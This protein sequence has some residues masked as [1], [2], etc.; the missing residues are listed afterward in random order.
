M[1]NEMKIEGIVET[2]LPLETFDSGFTKRV[3]VINTGGDY[4]QTVPVE[5]VKDK[6]EVLTGLTKG[7]AVTAHINI[8]GNEYNG[9]YYCN[10][11]GWKLDK[12]EAWK[13][14]EEPQAKA[15]PT[16]GNADDGEIP[17]SPHHEGF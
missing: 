16:G 1:N 2:V 8:R 6:T 7:Q 3:L 15:E 9:K 13:P 17:F 4:P 11:G 10:L 12:G 14:E 5:F